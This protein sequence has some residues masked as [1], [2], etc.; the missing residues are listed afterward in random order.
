MEGKEESK[1]PK[2]TAEQKRLNPMAAG[3]GKLN[4]GKSLAE[5]AAKT[6]IQNSIKRSV[7]KQDLSKEF[8]QVSFVDSRDKIITL[9]KKSGLRQINALEVAKELRKK[10]RTQT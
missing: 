10:L 8:K 7:T 9:S 5:N 1:A 3:A 6:A 2:L 4:V